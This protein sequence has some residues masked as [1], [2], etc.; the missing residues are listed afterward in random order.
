MPIYHCRAW[1]L[2]NDDLQCDEQYDQ[3]LNKPRA[4]ELQRKDVCETEHSRFALILPQRIGICE[5]M[6]WCKN[7]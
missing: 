2:D 6:R 1:L 3:R 5:A 4:H 7:M